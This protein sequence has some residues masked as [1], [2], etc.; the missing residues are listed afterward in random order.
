[1]RFL[2]ELSL[3]LQETM[4]SAR[5]SFP[6]NDEKGKMSCLLTVKQILEKSIVQ[7]RQW[8]LASLGRDQ[9]CPMNSS[10]INEG[11]KSPYPISGLLFGR[12]RFYVNIS[13]HVANLTNL[14]P[15]IVRK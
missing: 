2:L 4:H 11:K 3:C 9:E 5:R 13:G 15:R 6:D 12:P 10:F 7:Q 1:M 8:F 14:N